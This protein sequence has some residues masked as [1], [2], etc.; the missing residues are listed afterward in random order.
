M[1]NKN[2]TLTGKLTDGDL[3]YT[4]S[5][6]ALFKAFVDDQPVIAWEDLA[7]EIYQ[8]PSFVF[9]KK[10]IPVQFEGYYKPKT[11]TDR[12][13]QLHDS[14]DFTI[15]RVIEVDGVPYE[16]LKNDFGSDFHRE[17]QQDYDDLPF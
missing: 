13:G 16:R 10:P 6:K 4:P 7:E 17:E 8:S 14:N 15:T 9:R 3:I 1:A 12:Y 11:W 5:G 2:Q